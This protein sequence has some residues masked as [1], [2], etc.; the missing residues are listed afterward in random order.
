M[1]LE[2]RLVPAFAQG[3]RGQWKGA[4]GR[5][6][7]AGDVLFLDPGGGYSVLRCWKFGFTYVHFSAYVF[8]LMLSFQSTKYTAAK[9]LNFL[10]PLWWYIFKSTKICI[11]IKEALVAPCN[12]YC[13]RKMFI[14]FLMTLHWLLHVSEPDKARKGGNSEVPQ[15]LQLSPFSIHSAKATLAQV[16][17]SWWVLS[18]LSV[19]KRTYL[20]LWQ[21]LYFQEAKHKENT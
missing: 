20:Y 1:L 9:V 6:W 3:R 10:S 4:L 2:A 18:C 7:A 15:H 21:F 16:S 11:C 8:Y 14:F 13:G 12:L 19:S 5:S 17:T